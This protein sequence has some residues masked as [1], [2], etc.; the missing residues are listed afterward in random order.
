VRIWHPPALHRLKPEI[1]ASIARICCRLFSAKRCKF[2]CVAA[3]LPSSF[4]TCT[5]TAD[6]TRC[7]PL[8]SG[9]A[10]SLA[11]RSHPPES[12]ASE[13]P[14]RC[15]LY[16][17]LVHLLRDALE[18]V[19]PQRSSF[20]QLAELVWDEGRSAI[21]VI[22][23]CTWYLFPLDSALTV[24]PLSGLATCSRSRVPQAPPRRPRA[25]GTENLASFCPRPSSSGRV[26]SSTLD[27]V[28]LHGVPVLPTRPEKP[29]PTRCS[30]AER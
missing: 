8:P 17:K 9:S 12:I 30:F 6:L 24:K 13:V 21:A 23:L 1:S 7:L 5:S 19:G 14:S 27:G 29:E 15:R 22:R 16:R 28:R 10:S 3:A 11:P 26:E 18:V 2:G 4:G 25:F 20:V